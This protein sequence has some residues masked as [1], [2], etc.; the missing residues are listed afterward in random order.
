MEEERSTRNIYF[1]IL[2]FFLL[3]YSSPLVTVASYLLGLPLHLLAAASY[4]RRRLCPALP[5]PI[6]IVA[7]ASMPFFAGGTHS[8]TDAAL[9]FDAA[10]RDVLAIN[11]VAAAPSSLLLLLLPLK[12]REGACC[13][14][15]PSCFHRL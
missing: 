3:S 9:S 6:H 13:P 14:V 8:F 12:P 7:V 5:P 2:I 1:A 10:F 4:H 15:A 11:P